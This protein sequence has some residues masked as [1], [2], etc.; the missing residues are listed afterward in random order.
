MQLI[1]A[2]CESELG[3]GPSVGDKKKHNRIFRNIFV[4]AQVRSA[5]STFLK[6]SNRNIFC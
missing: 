6:N 1:S 5:L 3:S 2:E 4:L